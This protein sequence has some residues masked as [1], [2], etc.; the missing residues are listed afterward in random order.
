MKAYII[1]IEFID[2]KPLIWRRVIMPAGA[3]FNRLNDVIQNVTNFK[4]GYPYFDYHLYDFD[5]IDL[6]VTNDEEAYLEHHHYQANKEF[7]KKRLKKV[8]KDMLKFEEAYQNNLKKPVKKPTGVKID[9]YLE[10]L[11]TIKYTY[12]YGD[13]WEI[14]ITLEKVVDDYY[15]GYPTLLDGANNAP[16][17]DVGGLGGFYEFLKVINDKDHQDYEKAKAWAKSVNYR[18]YDI[19]FSNMILKSI[20]YKKNEWDKIDH[21]KYKIISDKYRND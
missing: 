10:N 13:N 19:E 1:K 3:T 5:L 14:L 11:K 9:K 18:E 16:P 7:Y 21:I 4:S 12:D 17:E 20:K 6:K 2:S 8:P 15:F